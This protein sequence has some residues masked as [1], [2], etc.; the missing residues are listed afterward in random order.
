M[1]ICYGNFECLLTGDAEQ[2]A[3]Q[4]MVASGQNLECDL[5]VVG[6]HGSSSSTSEELLEAASPGYAFLSAG[7]ENPYGHPTAQT[8]NALRRHNI[9]L[10]RIDA[11]GEITAYSDGQQVWF[12][13]LPCEDWSAGIQEVFEEP[14]ATVIPQISRYVLNTHTKKFHN[15]DCSSVEQMNDKNKT[16]TDASREEL[17]ARGYTACGR[18][19]P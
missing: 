3:E 15:P 13:T 9:S 7:K 14:L 17:I 12:S 2:E 5:Y 8:L 4:D 11:Q 16:F 10:Y 1:R 6:H 19:N 18:C